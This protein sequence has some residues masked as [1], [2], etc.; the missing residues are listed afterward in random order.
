M[1]KTLLLLSL[2]ATT[3]VNVAKA[4]DAAINNTFKRIDMHVNEIK[5]SPINGLKMVLTAEGVFYVTEDGKYILQAPLYDASGNR[6]INVTQNELISRM[7]ALENEMIVFKSDNEKHVVTIFTDPT[8]G[9]CVKLQ[10]S[11]GEYNK[12]GITVRYLAFPRQG[13]NSPEAKELQAVWCAK[14]KKDAFAKAAAGDKISDSSCNVDISR[15]YELGVQLGVT[16]TPAIVY[17]D[18]L[19]PGYLEAAQ[20]RKMLD[21]YDQVNK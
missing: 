20:L 14:D 19:M 6:L 5:S 21:V 1:K 7:A 9:F 16:G 15:H 2:L 17:K 18:M 12:E 8:C 13:I 3:F 4:D 10:N 11:I